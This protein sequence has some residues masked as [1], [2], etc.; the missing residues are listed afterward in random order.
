MIQQSSFEM[1]KDELHQ[2]P[3]VHSE[4]ATS[5][6]MTDAAIIKEMKD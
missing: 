4:L 2:Y 3:V 6:E 1:E 5:E